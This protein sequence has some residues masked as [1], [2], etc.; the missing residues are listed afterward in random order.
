[1]RC[2]W[3]LT[4][5]VGYFRR[6]SPPTVSRMAA[7]LAQWV[8]RLMGL[9][10]LGSWPTHTPFCTSAV[11][12]HPTEQW[13]QMFF[14]MVT[15]EPGFGCPM[16]PSAALTEPRRGEPTAASPPTVRPDRRRKARRSMASEARP[17]ARACSFPFAASPLL[18]LVSMGQP[19]LLERLV[20]IGA[21]EGLH[22]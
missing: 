3:P 2:H 5:L 9:S 18:R 19:S 21:V 15:G 12:V 13:V 4:S 6:R 22:V 7:P 10:Q 17:A 8:P 1:M 16:P 20:A 11:T 14:L